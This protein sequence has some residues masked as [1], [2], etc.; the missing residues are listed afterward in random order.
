VQKILLM[1][2]L[3]DFAGAN[4]AAKEY[5]ATTP[6][7]LLAA[8][9]L[10]VLGA[11]S[12]AQLAG[13]TSPARAR[14]RRSRRR[15]PDGPWGRRG[16]EIL[17]KAFDHIDLGSEQMLKVALKMLSSATTS[18]RSMCACRRARGEGRGQVGRHRA[19]SYYIAGYAYKHTSSARS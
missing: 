16:T 3:K 10:A 14:R 6:D 17:G 19:E 18:A 1:T 4:T 15:Q 12:D 7:A 8:Q 13:A 5:L 9:G 11:Q 2:E